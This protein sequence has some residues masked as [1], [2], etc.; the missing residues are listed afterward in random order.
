MKELFKYITG[1][2]ILGLIIWSIFSRIFSGEILTKENN[3]ADIVK[4]DNAPATIS[5]DK[6]GNTHAQ[7]EVIYLSNDEKELYLSKEIDSLK[8]VIGVKDN[9]IVG[10]TT[11]V[12]K[13]KYEIRYLT[14][15]SSAGEKKY[16]IDQKDKWFTVRGTIPGPDPITIEGIDSITAAFIKKGNRLFVDVS[17]ANP[18]IK[19]YGVRSFLVPDQVKNGIGIGLSSTLNFDH[20]FNYVT[21]YNFGGIKYMHI[22]SDWMYEVG[23]GYEM[24][25]NTGIKIQPTVTIGVYR[26]IF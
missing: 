4:I 23:A 13:F 16:I 20:K 2:A 25:N 6:K 17:S 21:N 14:D 12:S 7:K 11:A 22:G 26:K 19:Y 10:L 3:V 1:L 5:T 9:Q 8:S 15:T 24:L 18:L